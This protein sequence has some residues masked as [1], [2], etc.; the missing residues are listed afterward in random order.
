MFLFLV[1]FSVVFWLVPNIM[2]YHSRS[3]W[4]WWT[5]EPDFLSSTLSSSYFCV[6]L[7]KL[8]NLFVLQ[9]SAITNKGSV[10]I[11]MQYFCVRR[12]FSVFF[13]LGKMCSRGLIQHKHKL[14]ALETFRALFQRTWTI[15]H[16]HHVY[17]R[18][19]DPIAP[20]F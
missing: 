1:K 16:S 10:N 12:S 17:E 18:F 20:H 6:T 8:L 11:Q 5:L 4:K 3:E 2:L 9:F 19:K 15:L 13:S 14:S 7:G